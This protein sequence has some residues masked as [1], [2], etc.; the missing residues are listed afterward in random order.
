M[1][2]LIVL[3]ILLIFIL[4]WRFSS[5]RI[6]LPCP[7]WLS[8]MVETENPFTSIAHAHTIISH[9]GLTPGM[10]VLDAGCGPG[11][12]T[13]PLAHMVGSRGKV[14]AVDAQRNA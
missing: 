14:I 5:Q 12:L 4:L 2:L 9:L 10:S 7:S 3:V 1:R 6:H 13:L 11:R 8:W